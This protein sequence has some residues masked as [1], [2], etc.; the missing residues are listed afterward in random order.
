VGA[1]ELEG[2]VDE[3]NVHAISYRAVGL[4]SS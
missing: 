4:W 3:M 1:K 2:P